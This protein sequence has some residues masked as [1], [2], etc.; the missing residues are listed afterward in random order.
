MQVLIISPEPWDNQFVSKHHYAV[1]LASKGYK[2][3][4]LDPPVPSKDKLDI[5]QTNYE[6]I[7][8][9]SAPIVKKGLKYYPK[10][11]RNYFEKRWLTKLENVIGESFSIIWLFEN[12]RFFDMH[13]AGDRLKIYHQ[14]DTNQNYNVK[15][16]ATTADI[17]FCTT[18]YILE[19]LKK[20]NEKSYKIH[21][22]T[23]LLTPNENQFTL[24]KSKMSQDK[25]NAV[26][27]GNLDI[28]YLDI[29]I[30]SQ[31][32]EKYPEID[33]H[34][35]GNYAKSNTLYQSLKQYENIRWWGRI[36]STQ[37][38]AVLS[39]MDIQLLIYKANDDFDKKQLASPHK[40]M[41]YLAS[42]KITIATYTDEYK[43]KRDLLMMVDENE[44][45]VE[46]FS[47]VVENI[48]YYNSPNKQKQ[49][50]DFA[51]NNTY[52]KQLDKISHLIK[53]NN[54]GKL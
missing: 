13:F 47:K 2:I 44:I 36:D 27:I 50:I 1:A 41:E 42:G 37:I 54:L 19:E 39:H 11:L 9:I 45:Y 15:T 49:R 34:L 32:I 30:L 29:N 22:G 51:K 31:V 33:F 10:I 14:V 16:A 43:D 12:S 3:Y 23:S 53:Q 48:D 5:S 17:C 40:M 21:H 25:I 52:Q 38:P 26:Y 24:I 7:W 35:I 20:F 4:F 8:S 46:K 18:D 6:N 28:K